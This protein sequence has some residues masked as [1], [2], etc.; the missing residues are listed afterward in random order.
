MHYSQQRITSHKAVRYTGISAS[1]MA[2]EGELYF[3]TSRNPKLM[4][5]MVFCICFFIPRKKG[6]GSWIWLKKVCIFKL[7][8]IYICTAYKFLLYFSPLFRK[9]NLSVSQKNKNSAPL[10]C[11]LSTQL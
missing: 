8:S 6:L 9:A 3:A 7:I 5:Y 1:K 11:Y 4:A 2:G 10:F